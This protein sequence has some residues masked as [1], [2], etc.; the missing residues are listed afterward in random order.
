M[1]TGPALAALYRCLALRMFAKIIRKIN[2]YEF[3]VCRISKCLYGIVGASQTPDLTHSPSAN[4]P[5]RYGSCRFS[6]NCLPEI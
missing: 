3:P 5:F 6:F 1:N 4:T 2:E